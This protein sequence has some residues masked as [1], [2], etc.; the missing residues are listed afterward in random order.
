MDP[1]A[2]M[3]TR[4]RNAQAVKHETILFPHSALLWNIVKV[5]ERTRFLKKATRKGKKPKRVIELEL[6]YNDAKNP[7][8]SELRRISKP[9]RRIYKKV[10]ELRPIKNGIGVAILSTP[11]GLLTDRE[12][13]KQNMG[14]EMLLEI[15]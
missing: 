5:L 4:I 2:D 7:V 11:K 6:D 9:G 1:I 3:L 13:R 12:A 8:I 10:K 14:G 15:W